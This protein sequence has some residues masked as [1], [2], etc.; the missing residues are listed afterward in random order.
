MFGR[1]SRLTAL[2]A[3]FIALVLAA[4]SSSGGTA[5][6]TGA[7]LGA[8]G[9][10][11]P[12]ETM[13]ATATTAAS[14]EAPGAA[15]TD[16]SRTAG[17]GN[18]GVAQ[19]STNPA[20][21]GRDIVFTAEIAV[22][23]PDVVAAGEEA[24]RIIQSLGGFIFGQRTVGAPEPQTILVF[25]VFPEDF[26]AALDR[27]GSIGELRS[28]NVSADDV[29]ERVVDLQ[30]RIN[31]AQ[32]SVERLRG[33]LETAEGIEVIAQLE[34]QLL[35]RET[36][37]ETLRGQLRT[38]EDA[39]A[40]AT[41][42][43]SIAESTSRPE[44][45]LEVT[46]Y[47]GHDEAGLSCP[48]SPA[49]DVEESAEVTVCFEVTNVG[50][51]W[52]QNFEVRDPILDVALSDLLVVF[53]D[54][55]EAIEPGQSIM[56]AYEAIADRDLRTQTTVSAQPIAEDGTPLPGRD[57]S[58]TVS[59]FINAIDPGGIPTFAEGL[60]AS[61]EALVGIGKFA[62]LL[63]G[64]LLPFSWVLVVGWLVARWRRTRRSVPAT[65]PPTETE[66]PTPVGVGSGND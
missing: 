7:G 57:A 2:V 19:V 12:L 39:V 23:A 34:N 55:A 63:I 11:S 60:E 53:G 35:A 29:T 18:G 62:L 21:F 36:E 30:S 14:T 42:T 37:L 33:F 51:T 38:V 48:G 40:M 22:S 46:A 59:I 3:L 45:R 54:P 27:L 9:D 25:K 6:T 5:A 8:G 49:L 26:Q 65:P 52:L 64:A 31:T 17:L 50:D 20:D 13:A 32:A 41:I 61:W 44:I 15:G 16:D 10:S 28:Q 58:A 1:S 43:L 47:P 24:T 66:A 56:F 4:C